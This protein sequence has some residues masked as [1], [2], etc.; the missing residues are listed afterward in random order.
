MHLTVLKHYVIYEHVI[1]MP[2]PIQHK[3]LSRFVIH[4][5]TF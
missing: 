2:S 5:I 1:M 4:H 3:R